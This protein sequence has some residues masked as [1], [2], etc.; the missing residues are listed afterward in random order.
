M[1]SLKQASIPSW[2]HSLLTIPGLLALLTVVGVPEPVRYISAP[3][4][5]VWVGLLISV[6]ALVMTG[7]Y[8]YTHL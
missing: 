5:S 7:R 1:A 8:I 6:T 3:L 2:I 4:L